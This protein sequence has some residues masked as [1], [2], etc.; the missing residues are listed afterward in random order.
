MSKLWY[1][2][3]LV[4]WSVAGAWNADDIIRGKGD[5]LDGAF[6]A[7]AIGFIIW[8]G[9]KILAKPA[10]SDAEQRIAAA[11]DLVPAGTYSGRESTYTL[12]RVVDALE[13]RTSSEAGAE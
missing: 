9:R 10:P 6:I 3:M 5:W 1:L 7:A 4:T 2:V 8:N 11:L 12:N 13:G